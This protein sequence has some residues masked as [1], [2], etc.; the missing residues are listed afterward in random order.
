MDIVYCG[1]YF[2]GSN[3]WLFL[4]PFMDMDLFFES[5]NSFFSKQKSK[6]TGKKAKRDIKFAI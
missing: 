4:L 5:F 3:T 6:G 2:D 1:R